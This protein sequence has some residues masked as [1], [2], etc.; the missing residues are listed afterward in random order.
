MYQTFIFE[1]YP[2]LN[3]QN[4]G[5]KKIKVDLCSLFWPFYFTYNSEFFF[6]LLFYGNDLF[7]YKKLL[8]I[9]N[10]KYKTSKFG[11]FAH[12]QH[13]RGS[14]RKKATIL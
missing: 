9:V 4:L 11:N 7:F 1:R 10:P 5:L 3:T 12:F 13:A 8:E 6:L 2:I 14:N